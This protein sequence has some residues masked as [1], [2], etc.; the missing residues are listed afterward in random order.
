MI[1]LQN[2][3]CAL[4]SADEEI[5]RSALY[6]LKDFPAADAQAILFAAMGDESWRV[7]KDA[8]DNYIN[9]GPDLVS[10]EQ[11]LNLLRNE[12]N[13]GLRNSAAE[14][15]VRLGSAPSSLLISLVNDQDADVRKFV[16]DAMG[17]I[18]D[19]AFVTSLLHAL[20]DPEV[21][22]ASAAAE[23]L[24]ALGDAGAAEPLMQAVLR[25]DD[26]LFRYSALGAL[27]L[28]AAPVQ[29]PEE[30][31]KLADQDILR[32]AVFE[33]L[34]AI[35]D[36]SSFKLLLDG[37]SCPQ[38][39]SRAAAVKA[40]HKIY[41]RSSA[42]AQKMMCEALRS[43]KD[44]DV[45]PGLLE[46]IDKRDGALTEALIWASVM[47]RDARF[48]PLLVET[49]ADE[50]TA[51]TAL[52]AIKYF[53]REALLEIVSRYSNLDES[54]RS[55]LCLLISECGYSGFNDIIKEALHDQ[56]AQVRKAAAMSAG[57]LGLSSCVAE[58]VSLL[59]D[60]EKQVYRT[61]I[62]ALQSLAVS[63][64]AAVT[65]EVGQLCSSKLPHHR[66]AAAFLLASLDERDRLQQLI[67]DGDAQVRKAAVAAIGTC[68]LES[69]AP[70]LVA[71][72]GDSDPDVRIA[73]ADAL[74]DLHDT[75][76]L[77]ALE[78]ALNDEDIW[79]QSAVLKAISRIEPV[80]ALAII[81][82][83]H[84]AAGGLLMIT[85]L[86]ILEDIGGPVAEEII[87][88]SLQNSDKD[89]VRQA[90]KSLERLIANS[91]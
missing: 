44:S 55:G 86:R 16:I 24:G 18:G 11:L 69:F 23:Q 17:A 3:R 20:N 34:G 74:G 32:K 13:A 43:L 67:Q 22:V 82:N 90:D 58:L 62:T 73:V 57:K 25:R 5:R 42:A 12:D 41:R 65:A 48:I 35:S 54:G 6:S 4:Q 52:A 47:I 79:V 83:L 75:K 27:G 14:A 36:D 84:A 59:D 64:R 61:A 2:I 37:F 85:C 76:T 91:N 45:M 28:L 40:L 70:L 50:R 53:G 31:V 39:N 49:F 68:C 71:A 7:R 51:D 60:S 26:L 46:L 30:L 1:D 15:V 66:E 89:I 80:A 63:S 10:V 9:S 29:V 21:N 8:V 38:K 56:S 33:C 81:K 78:H 88:Y 77:D 72:L 19:P 87:R